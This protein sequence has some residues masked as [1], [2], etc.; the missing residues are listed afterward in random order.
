MSEANTHLYTEETP[1]A[2]QVLNQIHEEEAAKRK[3]QARRQYINFGILTAILL[4]IVL[5][6]ALVAPVITPKLV[7]AI[8]GDNLAKAELV[9]EAAD[10]V[11]ET[12]PEEAPVP[13]EVPVNENAYP[14][15]EAGNGAQAAPVDENAA[16]P[17]PVAPTAVTHQVQA[18]ETLF[19]IARQ[20]NL[21][22]EDLIR[23]NNITTPNNIPVGM[24]LV[25]PQ[26]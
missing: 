23:A 1:V 15:P 4:G 10:D 7:G 12:Q 9:R 5:V 6:V 26:P 16:Q 11:Q 18:G 21:T 3:Q 20:Y 8:M 19:S 22:T 2:A 24:V 25:I 13:E 17:E 14:A